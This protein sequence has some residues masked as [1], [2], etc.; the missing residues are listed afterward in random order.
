MSKARPTGFFTFL[1]MKHFTP[2]KENRFIILFNKQF[3]NFK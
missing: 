3:N 1:M 2:M